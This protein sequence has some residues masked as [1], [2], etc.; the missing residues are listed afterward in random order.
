MLLSVCSILP[1]IVYSC[2]A[3]RGVLFTTC[4][5]CRS[6]LFTILQPFAVFFI[7]CTD[8]VVFTCTGSCSVMFTACTVS[9]SVCCLQL[10]QPIIVCVISTLPSPSHF[11]LF[12]ACRCHHNF[13]VCSFHILSHCP[14][15]TSCSSPVLFSLQP[16]GR[17]LSASGTEN[18][19]LRPFQHF[20]FML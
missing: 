9:C 2:T 8:Y 11:V 1:C 16:S 15:F 3:S 17:D 18:R 20:S 13:V 6:V 14:L 4:T 10:P 12:I 5:V 19:S 7:V